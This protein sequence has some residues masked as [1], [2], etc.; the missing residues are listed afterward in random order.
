MTLDAVAVCVGGMN[1]MKTIPRVIG[2][3]SDNRTQRWLI[4]CPKCGNE[5]TPQTTLLAQQE[6]D[7]SKAKCG[8]RLFADYN[9]EPPVVSLIN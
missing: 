7:C 3:S 8:A 5:F 4:T 1:D 6:M 9:A 2:L